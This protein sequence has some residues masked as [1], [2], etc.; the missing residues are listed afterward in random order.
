MKKVKTLF[1]AANPTSTSRLALDEDLRD[2]LDKIRTAEHR[3]AFEMIVVPAARPDDIEQA[4]LQHKPVIVHFSGHGSGATGLAF[5]GAAGGEARLVSADAIG[6]LFKVL[7]KNVRVVILNAC[8]SAQQAKA[9]VREIDFVV[10]MTNTI[11][12]VGARKFAASFYRGLGFGETIN[13]AFEL[14]VNALKREHLVAD[15]SV[16]VL[17]VRS[18]M[19]AEVAL[20]DSVTPHNGNDEVSGSSNPSQTAG[21]LLGID[22]GSIPRGPKVPDHLVTMALI[23]SYAECYRNRSDAEQI[24]REATQMRLNLDA[25]ATYIKSG[26]VPDFAVG[27]NAYWHEVFHEACRHGPRMVGAILLA[28]AEDAA[29]SDKARRDRLSL[30]QMLTTGKML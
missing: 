21:G 10:G 8:Y 22:L 5:Q 20:L 2:I 27:A 14:G 4:L 11:S 26:H 3:D 7:K 16:P 25:D 18:G 29:F 6:H 23:D 15:E 17:L 30:L 28:V 24:L 12:D 13:T 9:I 1:L 19:S